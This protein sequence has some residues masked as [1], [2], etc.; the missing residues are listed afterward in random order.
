[1]SS[2]SWLQTQPV[3]RPYAILRAFIVGTPIKSGLLY[4]TQTDSVLEVPAATGEIRSLLMARNELAGYASRKRVRQERDKLGRGS[5]TYT[6]ECKPLAIPLPIDKQYPKCD[7]VEREVDVDDEFAHLDDA[8]PDLQTMDTH[9]TSQT[10]LQATGIS[11]TRDLEELPILPPTIDNEREC[12]R[13][14]ASD[15]C[16]LYRRV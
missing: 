16:M 11:L 15:A 13:C 4:Y 10:R 2:R 6:Q 14:Y 8:L 12:T 3:S 9:S 1:M 5:Q 7:P